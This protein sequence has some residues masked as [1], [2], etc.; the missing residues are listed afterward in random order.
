MF[1][2][3]DAAPSPTG[4][5]AAPA[6]N[7][8]AAGQPQNLF[9]AFQPL[10]PLGHSRPALYQEP[11]FPQRQALLRPQQY[12]PFAV[13]LAEAREPRLDQGGY[14]HAGPHAFRIAAAP[15]ELHANALL[16]SGNFGVIHGGTF[17]GEEKESQ[18]YE[19]P[20]HS[21]YGGNGHGRPAFYRGNPEPQRYRTAED[22]FANF[23]DFADIS[24]PTKSSF[25]EYYVVYVNR[26]ASRAD[27]GTVVG[28][29][30]RPP[31]SAAPATHAA[32]PN[33]IFE[34]L[35]QIDRH[36]N[37]D[38]EEAP[39]K[40]LSLAKRKL[41]LLDKK[42]APKKTSSSSASSSAAAA[43]SSRESTAAVRDALHEPLL[44]LS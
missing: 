4:E 9:P 5:P 30:G 44:A 29:E 10:F 38:G 36:S 33:N 22:F 43:T 8:D 16:G 18:D 34:R 13:P 12:S 20:L 3:P 17:Y 1:L 41:A 7:A 23:R 2:E 26:N 39:K 37:K 21:F 25:S 32:R 42:K 15:A 28:P 19:A 40:K 24:T 6:A 14:G 35:A 27:P 31:T 11:T